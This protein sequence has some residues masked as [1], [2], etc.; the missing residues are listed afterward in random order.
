[1]R[2]I[3]NHS[4]IMEFKPAFNEGISSVYQFIGVR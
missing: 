4:G 1:M 2:I 3:V